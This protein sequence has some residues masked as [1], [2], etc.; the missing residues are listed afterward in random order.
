[1]D[2]TPTPRIVKWNFI[3]TT[4]QPA[5]FSGLSLLRWLGRKLHE[6]AQL[7]TGRSELF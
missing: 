5:E 7:I 1:M 6:A 2:F 3:P 4:T